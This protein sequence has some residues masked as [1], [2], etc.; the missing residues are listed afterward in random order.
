MK[1]WE[2]NFEVDEYDW[3]VSDPPFTFEERHS[4]DGRRHLKTWKKVLVKR[5]E[6]EKQLELG[7]APRF[8]LP[9]LS[10]RALRYLKPLIKENTEVLPLK[11]NESKYFALN[12]ITV[13]DAI[14]YEKSV[15][16][17]FSDKKK[18]MLFD[19]YAFIE[20][21]ISNIPIFKIVDEP[22]GN[23]F[24]SDEFKRMVEDNDLLGFKFVL[25]WDSEE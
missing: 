3:L 6:P 15:Y 14:D 1:I 22:R 19:K 18:I 21:K 24:V 17:T 12:I 7:D 16:T 10:K 8:T 20:E 13:L 2:L 25:V 9:V 11:F 23:G 5:T 4:F